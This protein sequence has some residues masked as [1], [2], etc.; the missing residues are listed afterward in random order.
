[1]NPFMLAL[2]KGIVIAFVVIERIF[3]MEIQLFVFMMIGC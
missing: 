2:S 1:M 3:S